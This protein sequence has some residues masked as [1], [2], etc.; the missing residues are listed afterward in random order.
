MSNT[1]EFDHL[2]SSYEELLKDPIRDHFSSGTRFFHARKLLL[3]TVFW[4][5]RAIPMQGL[6]W[7]DIGCG[8]GD[9]LRLGGARFGKAMGCDVS[10][11]MM[12]EIMADSPR[13]DARRQPRPTVL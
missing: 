10:K 2:A 4:A 1:P 9:L 3:I 8:K 7:V 5:P 11:E 6:S 12:G 13:L